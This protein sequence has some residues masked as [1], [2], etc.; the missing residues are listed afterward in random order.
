MSGLP[1]VAG[2]E[3]AASGDFVI[4]MTWSG[5]KRHGRKKPLSS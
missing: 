1:L 5:A 2:L 4:E 3:R